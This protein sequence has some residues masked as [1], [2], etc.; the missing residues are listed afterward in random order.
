MN[1]YLTTCGRLLARIIQREVRSYKPYNIIDPIQLA[2]VLRPA[3]VL[4]VEGNQHVSI[5]IKYLTQSTWSHAAM[6]IGEHDAVHDE[7]SGKH[8]LIE[9]DLNKG[10]HILP[11]ARYQ[12]FNVR[13]CRPHALLAKD[14][15]LVLKY[16][17]DRVGTTYDLK[18]IID[19]LRYLIPTPPVPI[20]WRRRMIALGSG[21]PTR[22]ICSSLIAQAFQ[23]VRYPIL[24]DIRPQSHSPSG[25]SGYSATE[26][27]QIRHHSLFTPRDFDLSPYFSVIKPTIENGIDYQNIVWVDDKTV[28]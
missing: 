25:S 27:Y 21:D 1:R 11:L 13:I 20:R 12:N 19:L 28:Q 24:P 22:A 6:Y 14:M 26:M 2:K 15:K 3:D 5:A 17:T 4:L 7:K 10:C 18:N 9:V 23:S 16:M 8:A